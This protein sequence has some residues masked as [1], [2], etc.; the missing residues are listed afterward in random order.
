M[1]AVMAPPKLPKHAN[2]QNSIMLNSSGD[3]K[4]RCEII[5]SSVVAV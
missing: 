5:F 4:A 3:G 2:I 1:N